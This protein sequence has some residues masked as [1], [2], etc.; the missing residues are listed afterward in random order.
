MEPLF[1]SNR[2]NAVFAGHIHGYERTENV[3][4]EEI[5]DLAPMYVASE[6]MQR[7]GT[8]QGGT[9]RSEA[10]RYAVAASN[11]LFEHPQGPHGPSNTPQG[12][13]HRPT[14]IFGDMSIFGRTTK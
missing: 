10:T 8:P 4:F 9:S 7:R 14:N 11:E 12:A 2:V 1:N 6:L 13:P 5:D 3:A